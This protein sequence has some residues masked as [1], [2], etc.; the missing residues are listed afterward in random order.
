MKFQIPIT[1]K[2]IT[3]GHALRYWN[4]DFG[5]LLEFDH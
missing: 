3:N 2:K 5:I 4:L 1:N